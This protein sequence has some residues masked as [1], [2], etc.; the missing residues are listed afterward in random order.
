M[1]I[2]LREFNPRKYSE[3]HILGAQFIIFLHELG[4]Y[5]QRASCPIVGD[6]AKI[7]SPE[8]RFAPNST[9][10]GYTLEHELFG[11]EIFGISLHQ[12]EFLLSGS[13]PDTLEEFRLGLKKLNKF[14][15]GNPVIILRRN[16]HVIMLGGCGS[17][18]N[19][20]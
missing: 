6:A 4:H 19:K 15:A 11:E 17:Y 12:A 14:E 9:E 20:I 1:E 10:G 18:Y 13:Y 2:A 3:R 8:L 16:Q 5:L 7:F